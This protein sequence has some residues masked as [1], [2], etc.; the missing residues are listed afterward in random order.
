MELNQIMIMII[1]IAIS[2]ALI[3]WFWKL[4]N[5]EKRKVL[6]QII[7]S[8]VLEAEKQF[9][10]K[11]GEAKYAAVVRMFYSLMPKVITGFITPKLLGILIEE[12]V[13]EMKNYLEGNLVI[14]KII[15]S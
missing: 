15:T 4:T 14:Q 8:L 13:A 11:T 10:V 7:F 6:E 3:V 5:A 12:A 2:L 9:G 1:A